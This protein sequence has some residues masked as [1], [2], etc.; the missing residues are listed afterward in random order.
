MEKSFLKITKL[1]LAISMAF[2]VFACAPIK[3]LNSTSPQTELNSKIGAKGVLSINLSN[4]FKNKGFN[5]KGTFADVKIKQLKIEVYGSDISTK[6]I[7]HVDWVGGSFNQTVNIDIPQGKNR[8]VSVTGVDD[9]GQPISRLMSVADIY[10]NTTSTAVINYGTTAVARVLNNILNSNNKSVVDKLDIERLK[11][12]ITNITGYRDFDNTYFSNAGA[13]PSPSQIDVFSISDRIIANDGY[14]D[15]DNTTDLKNKLAFGKLKVYVKD[16]SGN[17]VLSNVNLAV[18]DITGNAPVKVNNYSNI[19]V[20]QGV[21][22]I[23]AKVYINSNGTTINFPLNTTEERNLILNGG[24]ILY[25][26]QQIVVRG[27]QEQEINL[28]LTNLK[29]KEI[30]LFKDEKKLDNYE[31]E[32]NNPQDLDA[33]VFYDDDSYSRDQV[34]WEINDSSVATITSSGVI[35]GLKRAS[36]NLKL[37]SILDKDKTA[38]FSIN[39]KDPG[40]APII[41]SFTG[42]PAG[43]LTIF[44]RNFDDQVPLNNIV[45]INGYKADVVEVTTEYIKVTIPNGGAVGSG[46]VTIENTNGSK[47]SDNIFV[48]NPI[49]ATAGQ[50]VVA[51]SFIMGSLNSAQMAGLNDLLTELTKEAKINLLLANP[52]NIYPSITTSGVAVSTLTSAQIKFIADFISFNSTTFATDVA[53]A[54][55]GT[56]LT[57][58]LSNS[59]YHDLENKL[60]LLSIDAGS[61][62][63][64]DITPTLRNY[65]LTKLPTINA[66]TFTADI[67]NAKDT[68]SLSVILNDPKYILQ[69]DAIDKYLKDLTGQIKEVPSFSVLASSLSD[70]QI[71]KIADYTG[72]S[73]NTI[74]SDVQAIKNLDKNSVQESKTKLIN[75]FANAKYHTQET[76]ITTLINTPATI[77]LPLTLNMNISS[78]TAPQLDFLA[79]Y[80]GI[81]KTILGNDI[82]FA[83]KGTTFAQFFANAKY[84]SADNVGLNT[85]STIANLNA[86]MKSYISQMAKINTSVL[87]L[88]LPNITQTDT[89]FNTFQTLKDFAKNNSAI[90]GASEGPMVLVNLSQFTMDSTEVNNLDFKK[91]MDADGYNK[92]EYWTDAGWNWK[93]SNNISQPLYWLD[94]KYNQDNQPVVGVS[95]Y[96]AYAYSKWVG[97]RLPTEAEWEFSAKGVT[98]NTSPWGNKLY[99]WGNTKPTGANTFTNGFFGSDGSA[100]GFKFTGPVVSMPNGNTP[101]TALSNMSGNVMEW[102]SDWYDYGYYGRSSDFTNPQGPVNGSFKSVRGGSWTHSADELR[103]SYRELFLRP[104]SRNLNLGF[105]C[106]KN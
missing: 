49:Q 95:W 98:T 106:A 62:L 7:K 81:N 48:G 89:V 100:D 18:N 1:S 70:T 6:I 75:L 20:D 8:V 2:S 52:T 14:I 88:A 12:L 103:A 83:T 16:K 105:R 96:E 5:T 87:D 90:Y 82:T 99:P 26:K 24:G 101:V 36:T 30:Q 80:L 56:T 13:N 67:T 94:S 42:G 25:A 102:V 45:K 51:G 17:A 32:I 46:K 53:N 84:H 19:D 79:D 85:T 9:I 66:A 71:Q 76:N 3:N 65:I 39:F 93:L 35:T 92:R 11:R 41:N 33:R 44:G 38:S 77:D 43:L 97:K 29:V 37:I 47:T 54:T 23:S 63:A 27:T 34:V 91:F 72:I 4:L 10:A 21:W 55:A 57:Q 40:L 78:I 61:V 73:Y 15:P 64:I 104:E 69:K 86:G 59:K 68:D 74:K 50:T 58:L 60:N 22:E 31:T 28:N